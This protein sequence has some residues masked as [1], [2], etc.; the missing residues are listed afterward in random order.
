MKAVVIGGTGLIGS[1][2][3]AKLNEHGHEAVAAAPETGVNTLTGEGL[4]QVLK[5]AD[6]VVDVSNSPSFADDAVMSFFRTSTGN[7]LQAER[8]AGV[9]HHVALSVVGTDRLQQSGYFRA[10]QAQEDLIQAS[11]TPYSIVHATQFFEFVNGIADSATQGGTVRLAPVKIQ[12][13]HSD[14]VAV[15]VGRAVVGDPVNGVVEVAGPEIF[16]LDELIRRALSARN[17]PR[18]VTADE[19]APYFGAVLEE[20]TLLPGAGAQLAETRFGDWLA[21]QN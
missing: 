2:L 4:P 6:V 19:Q 8:D 12:P 10:K 20:T 5:G 21:R 11:G 18:S 1:K 17:D 9:H 7:I 13:I 14:D 3:V 15:A 16:K